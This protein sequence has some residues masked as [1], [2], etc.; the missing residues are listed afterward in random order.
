MEENSWNS[1]KE[2]IISLIVL[3]VIFVTIWYMIDIVLLTF[4]IT[5]VFYHLVDLIQKK[6]KE[7]TPVRI[8]DGLVLTVLYSIFI[9]LLIF[10]GIVL[11]PRLA[12]FV[13]NLADIF[14]N[15]NV[16]AVKAVI[17]PRIAELLGDVDFSTYLNQAGLMLSF[18]VAAVG[19]FGLNL[20]LALILSFLLV[21]EKNKIKKFGEKLANSRISFIYDYLIKFGGNFCKTFGKVMKVQVTIA[22]INSIISMIL[23]TFLGFHQIMGLG[24]MIFTLG[25]VP[26][27]GVIISLIPLCIIA[28]NVGGISKVAAV[29]LMIVFIHMLEAYVLNPKLMSDQ[30]NLPVCF[31]FIILLVGEHYLKVWGLLIGVPLFIFLMNAMEVDY[32]DVSSKDKHKRKFKKNKDKDN[33]ITNCDEL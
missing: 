8:P 16:D 14:I 28:F 4:I 10:G 22:F 1:L 2:R 26:V 17:D 18:G 13:N 5:F 33:T 27:A 21:L 31:I 6:A 20:F 23:L 19:G 15:F 12:A 25:L 9:C 3:G 29:I 32:S 11:A 30:T 24:V 7:L